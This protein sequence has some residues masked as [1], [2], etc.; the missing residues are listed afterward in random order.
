MCE[1]KN[2]LEI[3]AHELIVLLERSKELQLS[4]LTHLL[5]MAVIEAMEALEGPHSGAAG[6]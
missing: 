5:S 1:D 6:K 3:I 2:R 4:T